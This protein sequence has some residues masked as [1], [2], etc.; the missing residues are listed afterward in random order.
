MMQPEVTITVSQWTSFLMAAFAGGLAAGGRIMYL[1]VRDKQLVPQVIAPRTIPAPP[2]EHT[3]IPVHEVEVA[4]LPPPAMEA[5][6]KSQARL[7]FADDADTVVGLDTK[8]LV[9]FCRTDGKITRKV[10]P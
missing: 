10:E 9:E 1:Y 2:P 3:E 5:L 8:E 4:T 7:V 6:P